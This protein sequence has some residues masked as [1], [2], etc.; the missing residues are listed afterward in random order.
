MEK[1]VIKT[2]ILEKQQEIVS[3]ELVER[4]IF[5]EES[6]NYVFVGLRRAGKSYLMFQHIQSLIKSGKAVIEDILYI[7]FEDERI[8][9][10]KV[11][12]LNLF[13]ESYRELYEDKRPLL[14]LDEIQNIEGW[15]H[16]AR[17]L[18]DSKY[19]VYIT[20]SNAKMLSRDIATTLGGRYIVKEI[21]PFSFGEYLA[22][23]E[24]RLSKN[25]EYTDIRITVAKLFESY[26]HF[27]G[28]PETFELKDKRSWINS[29]YLK[30]LLG[31]II[32]RNEI[33]NADAIRLLARKL[34][35]S[36]MQPTTLSRLQH[37]VS[38]AGAKVSR[39][40]VTDY[41][42]YM[43]D[44]YLIF[45]ISNFTDSL[46]E[47]ET[48]QKRY[49]CD[50]GLLNVFLADPQTKLLENIVALALMKRF[51]NEALF[52]YNKNIEVDFYLPSEKMAVQASFSLSDSSTF[53]RETKALVKIA[54]SFDIEKAIIVTYD[55]EREIKVDGISIE[56]VPVWKWLLNM[57]DN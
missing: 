35:E 5:L 33:R 46:S 42:G 38:S 49:F 15:E 2:I 14:Y 53:E 4:P 57:G 1:R 6:C 36:V 45:G 7:N 47:R 52:Y 28:F 13:L 37:I 12:E 24:I 41:I 22:C 21:Y 30:I 31:D 17:R 19:K 56:V 48:S 3:T 44:A 40:T 16:F 27:G 32:T 18:A 54:G 23:K 11:D 9:S 34:A 20:G 50:N 29:L 55:D 43:K 26:F 39:N 25:W 8:S 10:V 51:G